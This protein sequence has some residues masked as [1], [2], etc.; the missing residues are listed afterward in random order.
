MKTLVVDDSPAFLDVASDVV[1]AT[2]GFTSVG[3]VSSPRLALELLVSREPELAVIDFHMPEMDGIELTRRFK[4]TRPA[5]TV[6]LISADDLEQLPPAA[7]SCGA[8][9]ILDKRDFG[10][11]RLREIG[12]SLRGA[13]GSKPQG[14]RSPG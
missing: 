1:D 11:R 9:E 12:A 5:T 13:A 6:A 10:P 7:R 3:A 2:P 8:D 4:A 14:R